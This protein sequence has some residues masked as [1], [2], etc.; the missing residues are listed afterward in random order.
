MYT[1][2]LFQC[3]QKTM[4]HKY[5]YSPSYHLIQVDPEIDIELCELK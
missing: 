4:T 1:F 5:D 3:K 2:A